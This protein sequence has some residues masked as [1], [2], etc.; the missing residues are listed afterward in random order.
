MPA[1]RDKAGRGMPEV[2]TMAAAEAPAAD[3]ILAVGAAGGGKG[4]AD[5]KDPGGGTP[6][7]EEK[8]SNP[9]KGS[10]IKVVV[11]VRPLSA[12]EKAR[13][14][15]ATVEVI[16]ETHVAAFDPDDKMGGLDYLRLDKTKTKHY[17]FDFAFGPDSTQT[18]VYEKSN[19]PLVKKAVQGYNACCFAY[20]AVSLDSCRTALLSPAPPSLLPRPPARPRGGL[21]HCRAETRT[22]TPCGWNWTR[23]RRPALARRLL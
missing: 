11:R 14:S 22:H 19:K 5:L 12:K 20:G 3:I 2:S 6:L 17:R 7:E 1:E 15:W 23:A 21:T 8:A 13:D 10:N 9:E 18:E 4:S 16:D